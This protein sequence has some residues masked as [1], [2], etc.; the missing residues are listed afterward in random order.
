M[1]VLTELKSW[2]CHPGGFFAG[3]GTAKAPVFNP[4]IIDLNELAQLIDK[5]WKRMLAL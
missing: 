1:E 2:F 4:V 5:E 3:R